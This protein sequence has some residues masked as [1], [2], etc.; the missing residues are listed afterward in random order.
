MGYKYNNQ[1]QW[2]Q[3]GMGSFLAAFINLGVLAMNIY[4][5]GSPPLFF[6]VLHVLI[7]VI[8]VAVGINYINYPD[9]DY[10]QVDHDTISIYRGLF[11][12]RKTIPFDS[13]K[14]VVEVSSIIELKFYED[15]SEQLLYPEW[16][17]ETDANEVKEK[18][19]KVTNWRNTNVN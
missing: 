14:R 17:D 9:K 12:P 16:L 5:T 11:I 15:D 2:F 10:I 6:Y 19:R 13:I 18:L 1:K 8:G 4:T 7:T 3:K